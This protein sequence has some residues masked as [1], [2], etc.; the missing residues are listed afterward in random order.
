MTA[1]VADAGDDGDG[2]GWPDMPGDTSLSIRVPEADPL[3]RTVSPAHVTVMYP[4]LPVSRIDAAADR[5]LALLFGSHEPFTLRFREFRRYPGVL[6][7]DPGP[8]D[9]VRTLTKRVRERWPDAIPYRGIFGD[10]GLDPHMTVSR[11]EGPDEYAAAYDAL[12]A[13][14]APM[15]PL[16]VHVREVRLAVWDGTAWHDRAAYSL[17]RPVPSLAEARHPRPTA[18]CAGPAPHPLR[19]AA[20]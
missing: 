13:E 4:F 6:L 2:D 8:A 1:G 5:D 10:E 18:G 12:E 19:W 20:E 11:G 9:P 7:L 14:L 16:N 3:V 15:L 17:G